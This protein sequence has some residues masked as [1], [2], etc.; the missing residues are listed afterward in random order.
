MFS[1]VDSGDLS[2]VVWSVEISFIDC[3]HDDEYVIYV[4]VC[5]R[6]MLLRVNESTYM[7]ALNTHFQFKSCKC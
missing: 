2:V 6:G 7:F 3:M 4:L 1:Y 5:M